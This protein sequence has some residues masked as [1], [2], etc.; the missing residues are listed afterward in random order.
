MRL[1]VLCTIF[2]GLLLLPGPEVS[3]L[4]D[5]TLWVDIGS[6]ST[7]TANPG[8]TSWNN[9]D[10]T[11]LNTSRALIDELGNPSGITWTHAS[12]GLQGIN[13]SGTTS[14]TAASPLSEFPGSATRDSAYGSGSGST[15][16]VTL[17]GFPPNT[18]VDI[19]FAAS[20]LG[21]SDNRT[22]DYIV[23]GFNGAVVSLD[24][25]NNLTQVVKASNVLPDAS[26]AITVSMQA[27]LENTNP[28]THYFYLGALKAELFAQGSPPSVLSFD[29][30]QLPLAVTAGGGFSTSVNV[31]ENL[32]T[33]IGFTLSAIDD[34]TGFTPTWLSLPNSGMTQAPIALSV[35]DPGLGSDSYSATLV[36][37]APGVVDATLDLQLD[38]QM[39]GALNLLFYGNS[40]SQGN[41]GMPSLA[42]FI[43]E[44]LG[45]AS[46]N[47]VAQLVGGQAL[48]YHLT[49]PAQAAAITSALPLGQSWDFVVMQ[50]LSTEA[51]QIGDPAAFRANA[52]AILSNV[53]AHSPDAKAVM[54]Q[55]WA[56][57]P[58]YPGYPVTWTGP[59]D[60]HDEIRTN[61]RL[62]VDDMNNAFGSGTAFLAAAGDAVALLAFDPDLYTSDWS[63]PEPPTTLLTAMVV[64]QAVWRARIS[65]QDP[66]FGAS[67]N[68]INRLNSIGLS[69]ADWTALSGIAE[70][71]AD[72]SLRRHPGSGE[73]LLL[74][75]S[76][77]SDPPSAR[78]VSQAASGDS[79]HVSLTSPNALYADELSH[80]IFDVYPTGSPPAAN[81]SFPEVHIKPSYFI[82]ATSAPLGPGLPL[83]VV[84]PPAVSGL[85][86]LVQ[87]VALGPSVETGN[88]VFTTT[89]GH[90][91][92]LL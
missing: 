61:Y 56:R 64:Y 79:F 49:N 6:S 81:P 65:D 77:N 90:E 3:A 58:E 20:R 8:G 23:Q 21:V 69:A 92:D 25:A 31:L 1:H 50:G 17:T 89:D 82:V 36:A 80:I 72:A 48:F 71:V 2:L 15:A 27:G 5:K 40:Y 83:T 60:M 63:H 4:Q 41:S 66:D 46:P 29:S 19:T 55:T 62:A 26:G 68:L 24:P 35:S 51:T 30:P 39:P 78:P 42:G 9:V 45:Q 70:R 88:Q 37:S 59:L 75:T 32:S 22:T 84:V 54:F 85:S 13:S 11:T 12:G 7:S 74:E 87:G 76:V 47:I 10:E 18:L 28:T 43:A 16:V 33:N 34:A 67:T 53:K 14:P 86:V 38:V 73:D 44:D 57:G 91:V 52:L